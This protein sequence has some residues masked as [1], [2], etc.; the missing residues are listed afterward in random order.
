MSFWTL[1]VGTLLYCG[2]M[3]GFWWEKD[4]PHALVYFGYVIAN[5]GF[6]IIAWRASHPPG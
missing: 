6:L 4:R 5:L 3:I 2:T 1:L